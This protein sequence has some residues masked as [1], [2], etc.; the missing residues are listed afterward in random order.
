MISA[1][2]PGIEQQPVSLGGRE[3]TR[4][5]YGDD[6]AKDYLV[7]SG[8]AV[9]VAGKGHETTQSFADRVE[10]LDDRL[11]AIRA[12]E[13]LGWRGRKHAGA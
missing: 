2:G 8:D 12:L 9:I 6:G 3:V 7:T 10:P 11:V 4:I 5:D 13:T 1:T